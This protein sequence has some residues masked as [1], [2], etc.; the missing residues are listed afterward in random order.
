MIIDFL[1]VLKQTYRNYHRDR[2]NAKTRIKW[3]EYQF[4][5]YN[6]YIDE[7]REVKY[8]LHNHDHLFPKHDKYGAV[9]VYQ[10][11]DFLT[12]GTKDA[13]G[14]YASR[15]S[16]IQS[17]EMHTIDPLSVY[18][19]NVK[20]HYKA[21]NYDNIEHYCT[22]FLKKLAACDEQ[23]GTELYEFSNNSYLELKYVK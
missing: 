16:Y 3:L 1:Y 6:E 18:I 10:F 11:R 12:N 23:F 19:K 20:Q 21:H 2:L 22:M 8:T 17:L 4:S 13:E 14:K 7:V 15:C 5:L 9:T